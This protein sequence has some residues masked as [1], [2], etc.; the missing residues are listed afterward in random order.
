[1]SREFERWGREYSYWGWNGNYLLW[2]SSLSCWFP[3]SW[4][5]EVPLFPAYLLQLS[6]PFDF[7]T[8][9]CKSETYI[10]PEI[11]IF[12]LQVLKGGREKARTFKSTVNALTHWRSLTSTIVCPIINALSTFTNFAF[13]GFF[14]SAV[15]SCKILNSCQDRSKNYNFLKCARH[16]EKNKA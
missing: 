14:P 9:I 7:A 2:R 16:A 6:I 10:S 8:K 4:H 3:S 12:K 5:Q 11:L 1:M 15:T 13:V